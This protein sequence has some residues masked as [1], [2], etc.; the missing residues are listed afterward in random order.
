[1]VFR[2][3]LGLSSDPCAVHTHRNL[4]AVIA[5][6]LRDVLVSPGH[7]RLVQRPEPAHH[8]D[9]A[10]RRVRHVRRCGRMERRVLPSQ[11]TAAD[12]RAAG[13]REVVQLSVL[14]QSKNMFTA[15]N[16]QIYLFHW[17]VTRQLQRFRT[18]AAHSKAEPNRTP[19]ASPSR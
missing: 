16:D 6:K 11:P 15:K 10:L 1:M 14:K 4:H 3:H 17:N 18:S 12:T 13:S 7:L 5:L 8:L 2:L 19:Q 9:G